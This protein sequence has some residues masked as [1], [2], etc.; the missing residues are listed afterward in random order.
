MYMAGIGV[1]ASKQNDWM[2]N[3]FL[4]FGKNIDHRKKNINTVR[5][6]PLN[7]DS[8]GWRFFKGLLYEY[9]LELR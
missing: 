8:N 4:L 9:R 3:L 7:G 2:I 5:N 6:K 1:M